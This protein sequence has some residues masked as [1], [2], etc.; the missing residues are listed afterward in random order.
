VRLYAVKYKESLYFPVEK[1]KESLANGSMKKPDIQF[2]TQIREDFVTIFV[3]HE[4]NAIMSSN[5]TTL[6]VSIKK[7]EFLLKH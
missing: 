1:Y 2:W 4:P 7:A 3:F 5:I 6:N